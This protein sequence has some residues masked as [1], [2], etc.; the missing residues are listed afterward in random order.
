MVEVSELNFNVKNK[1]KKMEMKKKKKKKEEE[2]ERKKKRKK[3]KKKHRTE[4]KSEKKIKKKLD[5]SSCNYCLEFFGFC[6]VVAL[7]VFFFCDLL[8]LE[9]KVD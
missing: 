4:K 7:V 2:K 9:W 5:H 3:R 1:R 8:A 6:F